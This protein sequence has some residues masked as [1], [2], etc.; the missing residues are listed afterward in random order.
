MAAADLV[1][2][3][4]EVT[5]TVRVIAVSSEETVKYPTPSPLKL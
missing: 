3:A 5:L 2:S 1:G 4:M